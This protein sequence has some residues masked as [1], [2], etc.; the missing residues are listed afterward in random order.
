MITCIS[1]NCYKSLNPRPVLMDIKDFDLQVFGAG[2][3]K[4]PYLGYV[5]ADVSIPFLSDCVMCVPILVTPMTN[6]NRQVPVI[7]GTNIIRMCR[8][9][10][11]AS[12]D[13]TFPDAWQ[14]A[15]DS[16]C[17]NNPMVV[18]SANTYPVS[19]GPNQVKTVHGLV[20]KVGNF[21]T[22]V[23]EQDSSL[24]SGN[25]VVCPRVVSLECA[26]GRLKRIP[27]RI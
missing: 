14:S 26:P 13:S 24:Q 11:Q 15:V 23:T 16:L 9:I 19:I 21:S 1:E 27:V 4:L 12:S 3:S 17:V 10:Q 25:L 8:D 7:V 2:G 18:K 20:P 6:Y 5:E 22:A